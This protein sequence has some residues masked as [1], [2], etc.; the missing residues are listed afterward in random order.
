VSSLANF[1]FNATGNRQLV[2]HFA[3]G[4][5][6]D[7]L[8]EPKTAGNVSGAGVFEAGN[9]VTVSAEARPG[10]IF[11][12]W[13]EKDASK[14]DVFVSNDAGYTFMA[15]GAPRLLTAQFITLPKLA[16][17]PAATPGLLDFNW[18]DAPGWVL[19]ESGDLATWDTTMRDITTANGQRSVTVD[20]S[21]G[22]VFFR[23]KHP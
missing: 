5:R 21:D 14:N 10:Y 18:P 13:T 12:G 11:I 6:L 16:I 8:A 19:E 15:S 20:P 4:A 3:P 23:L 2:A 9:F 22:K 1:T 7:L 17:A